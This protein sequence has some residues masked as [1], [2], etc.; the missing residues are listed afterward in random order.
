MR[1]LLAM[2]LLVMVGFA[3]C[4][5]TIDDKEFDRTCPVWHVSPGSPK[6]RN[7][8]LV[9]NATGQSE[10]IRE[11]P[12]HDKWIVKPTVGG[13]DYRNGTLDFI[14]LELS[15]DYIIDGKIYFQAYTA[16]PG[17]PVAYDHERMSEEE[18]MAVTGRNLQ[19]R[20]M[21]AP[22]NPLVGRITFGPAYG[23]DEADILTDLKGSYRVELTNGFGDFDPSDI[24][25]DVIFEA[26]QDKDP[27]T[28]SAAAFDMSARLWYRHH[29]CA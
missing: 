23:H 4:I 15:V 29:D 2:A 7:T 6:W 10:E 19:F 28:D 8:A 5:T 24:R 26:D 14:E 22:G 18:Y 27:Q 3:G 20:D 25:I 12:Q 21:N 17:E 16:A 11:N 1:I 9:Y 13:F